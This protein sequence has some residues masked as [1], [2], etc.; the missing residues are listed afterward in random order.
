MIKLPLSINVDLTAKFAVRSVKNRQAH[1]S[2]THGG[3]QRG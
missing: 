3:H 2:V 1:I